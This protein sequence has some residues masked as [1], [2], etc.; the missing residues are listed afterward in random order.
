MYLFYAR[1]KISSHI[2]MMCWRM[3]LRRAKRY[4][5]GDHLPLWV[6]TMTAGLKLSTLTGMIAPYPTRGEI[7]KRLASAF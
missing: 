5:A 4:S 3:M 6:L 7:H 1:Q 2:A